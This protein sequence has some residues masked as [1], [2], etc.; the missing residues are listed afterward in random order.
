MRGE[1]KFART[2]FSEGKNLAVNFD[3]FLSKYHFF[4]IETGLSAKEPL[5][6][7]FYHLHGT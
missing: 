6:N 4:E 5:Y 3:P 1:R 2:G 7:L